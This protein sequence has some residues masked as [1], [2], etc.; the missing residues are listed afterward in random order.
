MRGQAKDG[1]CQRHRHPTSHNND[2]PSLRHQLN[3]GSGRAS[4]PRRSSRWIVRP[5]MRLNPRRTRQIVLPPVM[6]EI[7]ES[8]PASSCPAGSCRRHPQVPHSREALGCWGPWSNRIQTAPVPDLAF[9]VRRLGVELAPALDDHWHLDSRSGVDLIFGISTPPFS[10]LV[11]KS[12]SAPFLPGSGLSKPICKSRR[13]QQACG[14]RAGEL[15]SAWRTWISSATA[16]AEIAPSPHRTPKIPGSCHRVAA[17][18]PDPL[19]S[20]S[21]ESRRCRM[22]VNARC[23]IQQTTAANQGLGRVGWVEVRLTPLPHGRSQGKVCQRLA[24]T[25][26]MDCFT[27]PASAISPS[28]PA[29]PIHSSGLAVPHPQHPPG[30]HGLFTIQT[31]PGPRPVPSVVELPA[32][33]PDVPPNLL[34]IYAPVALLRDC[35]VLYDG[36]DHVPTFALPCLK[37]YAFHFPFQVFCS[38]SCTTLLDTVLWTSR[39]TAIPCYKPPRGF[40]LLTPIPSTA[41]SLPAPW[42]SLSSPI[43]SVTTS[44]LAPFEID[45]EYANLDHRPFLAAGFVC[46]RPRAAKLPRMQDTMV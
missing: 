9:H 7:I 31:D 16:R 39:T 25:A 35:P 19:A 26:V 15:G 41:A 37:L 1:S 10:P 8:R 14:I 29:T 45:Q 27:F 34:A 38:C 22:A 20:A 40:S 30:Q 32:R 6:L 44:F 13:R 5:S 23:T 33:L 2:S 3:H 17:S 46:R 42:N 18:R 12:Q 24:S 21:F 4:R 43:D 11:E 36:E 28:G